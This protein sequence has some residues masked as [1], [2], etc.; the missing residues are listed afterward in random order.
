MDPALR[1][2]LLLEVEKVKQNHRGIPTTFIYP[3]GGLSFSAVTYSD[4]DKTIYTVSKKTIPDFWLV[5]T[6]NKRYTKE[7]QYRSE[8]LYATLESFAGFIKSTPS[9][10]LEHE[11]GVWASD[12]RLSDALDALKSHSAKKNMVI[13]D[14]PSRREQ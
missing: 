13:F 5:E 10:A 6:Q 11:G 4:R 12:K 9:V 7:F 8:C 2:Y 14:D 1:L 3:T